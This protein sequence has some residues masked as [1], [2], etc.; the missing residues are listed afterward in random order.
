PRGEIPAV[1]PRGLAFGLE[2]GALW[3]P[4]DAA[5]SPPVME[6]ELRSL[7]GVS[8]A[9]ADGF[10]PNGG[11]IVWHPAGGLMKIGRERVSG[12]AGL[13]RGAGRRPDS[14]SHWLAA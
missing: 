12:I 2:G 13:L 8:G 5:L 11:L 1:T 10:L 14:G 4:C 6:A 7:L 9:A 3:L